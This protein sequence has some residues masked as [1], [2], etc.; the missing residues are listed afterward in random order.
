MSE[1][2]RFRA[3]VFIAEQQAEFRRPHNQELNRRFA[4]KLRTLSLDIDEVEVKLE[5]L[6][7][8]LAVLSGNDTRIGYVHSSIE[9]LM[10]ELRETERQIHQKCS[11]TR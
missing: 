5:A 1:K 3:H 2:P 8:K 4:V 9:R 7:K 11:K 10:I 6:L